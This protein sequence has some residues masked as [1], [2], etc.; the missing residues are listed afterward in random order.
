M[1]KS[2]LWFSLLMALVILI[3]GC[4]TET[5]EGVGRDVQ[6]LGKKIEG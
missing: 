4:H 6:K 5:M 3:T 2:I 1:K